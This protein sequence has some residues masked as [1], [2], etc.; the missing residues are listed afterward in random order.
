MAE[1]TQVVC[2]DWL[3]PSSGWFRFEYSSTRRPPPDAT[4]MNEVSESWLL[5]VWHSQIFSKLVAGGS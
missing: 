3:L 1:L 2:Q 4:T 5:S